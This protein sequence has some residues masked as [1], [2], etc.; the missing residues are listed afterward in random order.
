MHYAFK[1]EQTTHRHMVCWS[2]TTSTS[3]KRVY[4]CKWVITTISYFWSPIV[5]VAYLTPNDE[6]AGKI[7][8]PPVRALET[9]KNS[10]FPWDNHSTELDPCRNETAARLGKEKQNKPNKKKK[11]PPWLH[12]FFFVSCLSPNSTSA[13]IRL[14]TPP[15]RSSR[16]RKPERLLHKIYWLNSMYITSLLNWSDVVGVGK[17]KKN[18]FKRGSE[19]CDSVMCRKWIIKIKKPTKTRFCFSSTG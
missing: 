9:K 1:Q 5:T 19:R 11:T 18:N 13:R 16:R 7:F 4:E 2:L 12:F 14:R 8:T 6:I 17:P 10:E 3:Q 15:T